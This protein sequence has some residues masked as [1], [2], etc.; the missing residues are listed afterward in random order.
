MRLDGRRALVT[1]AGRGIGLAA[2]AALAEVG[3]YVTLVAR[4]ANEIGAI[5]DEIRKCGGHAEGLVLDVTDV[6]AVRAVISAGMS[7]DILVNNAG[8]NRPRSFLDVT[9]DDYDTI[10]TLN[11]R[12]A[13]FVAQTVARKMVEAG[14]GGSI[15]HISSQMGHVGGQNRSVYCMTKHG[16]EGFTK[17]TAIDLAPFGIRV[18][19]I[20]PTFIDTP[21]TQPFFQDRTFREDVLRRIKLGRLGT[22]EDLMGAIVFLAGDAA[23]LVTGTALVVDGGWTAD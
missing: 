15:I 23:S 20:G 3:A 22:V 10:T 8:T 9:E 17:A 21:L 12:A 14:K 16:I 19:S 2:A 1:G 6:A 5:A 18:N 13:Y 7:Y 11:L 4:T